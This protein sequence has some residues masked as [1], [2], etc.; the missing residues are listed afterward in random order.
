[1]DRRALLPVHPILHGIE[2]DAAHP[3]HPFA[4]LLVHRLAGRLAAVLVG[5]EVVRG[6][7]VLSVDLDLGHGRIST[8]SEGSNRGGFEENELLCTP[9]SYTHLRAHETV[10]D[11]VC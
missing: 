8:G 11:L 5:P 4:R 7:A 3:L 1:M 9:V 2:V 6:R 10:L